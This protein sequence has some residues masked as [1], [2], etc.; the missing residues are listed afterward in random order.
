MRE[1]S[2]RCGTRSAELMGTRG[3]GSCR[4]VARAPGSPVTGLAMLTVLA[5]AKINLDLRILGRRADGFH[6]LRT[7]FQSLALHD[8]LAVR[9]T[10]GPFRLACDRAGRAAR[11]RATWCGARRPRRGDAAGRRGPSRRRDDCAREADAGRGGSGRRQQRR[12]G[13]ARGGEPRA[14]ARP[15]GRTPCTAPRKASG[16]TCRSSWSAAP[17]SDSAEATTCIRLP[18]LPRHH[19]VLVR[20]PFGVTTADAYRWFS[21]QGSGQTHRGLT[22]RRR[23]TQRGQTLPLPWRAG[24][25]SLRNDL[26]AAVLPR[27]PEIAAARRALL[28][29]GA[30]AALMSGSGSTVFGLFED[31]RG[32]PGGRG[33][34]RA[35]RLD[36]S[37]HADARPGGLSPPAVGA[38]GRPERRRRSA[39]LPVQGQS[40]K[41]RVSSLVGRSCRTVFPL[42]QVRTA[43][44]APLERR[45]GRLWPAAPRSRGSSTRDG[46]MGRGQA[47]RRGT[48]DPV[49]EGSNPSAPA[50]FSVPRTP[51][52][53][54]SGRSVRPGAR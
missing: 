18:D 51:G 53:A 12:G 30:V 13:D 15:R 41:L 9:P 38:P 24:G 45:S 50:K 34:S 46:L 37:R 16:R 32:R 14:A 22:Q 29:K 40:G 47:V 52:A 6:E 8:V 39:R 21:D 42:F 1:D 3:S 54:R 5:S 25:L 23:L 43:H 19:V 7:V 26:E 10:R 11:S 35:P 17:R 2:T 20:P 33:R 48:L 49:F 44:R 28:R 31:G 27:H 4:T 36:G